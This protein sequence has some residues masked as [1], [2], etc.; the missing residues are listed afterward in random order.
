MRSN[1]G[2]MK[3]CEIWKEQCEAA[4]QIEVESGPQKAFDYLIGEKL[5][6]FLQVAET[7]AEFADEIPA[8]AAEINTI[9]EAWQVTEY[10]A[11]TFKCD[12]SDLSLEPMDEDE[13]T[14]ID[15]EDVEDK[16]Q[17]ELRRS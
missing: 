11:T 10:L 8:F 16:R 3:P 6:N 9:F 12:P 1:G 2:I 13:A 14:E 15:W 4:R 17:D 7:D 5:L